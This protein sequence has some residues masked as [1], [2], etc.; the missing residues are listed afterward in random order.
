MKKKKISIRIKFSVL[1]FLLICVI[2]GLSIWIVSIRIKEV[3]FKEINLRGALI[4]KNLSSENVAELLMLEEMNAYKYDIE[5]A[6]LIKEAMNNE[7][8]VYAL[9]VDRHG[10]IR[11]HNDITQ[12]EKPYILPKRLQKIK[13]EKVLI[14][15]YTQKKKLI[16]NISCP[17]LLGETK[18]IGTVHIGISHKSI[19]KAI[20]TTCKGIVLISLTTLSVGLLGTLIL[21]NFMIKP[22]HKLVKGVSAIAK[23]DLNQYIEV[24]SKDEIGELTHAFN[25]MTKSLREKELIKNAFARYVTKQVLEVILKEPEKIILGGEKKEVTILFA[26]IRGFTSIAE[27][28]PPEEVVNLL[29]EYLSLMTEII[30]KYEGTLDKFIGD[31]IMAVFGTPIAHSDDCQRAVKSAIDIQKTLRNSYKFKQNLYIGIGINNGEVISGNIGSKERT[32]YTVIGDPVNI[33]A[34]LEEEAKS[35]QILISEALYEKVK[36]IVIAEKLPLMHLKGKKTPLQIYNVKEL[37]N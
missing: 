3:L 24:Q 21:V 16:Y 33:A 5:F 11:A 7:S 14:Q 19:D 18:R 35:E 17:I 25:Q 12:W 9:I 20:F 26:D 4:A 13:N 32:D 31:C 8:I 30:F 10:K 29:N 34:R 28:L 6:N 23:G 2:M 37:R 27:N 15:L 1:I 22:I 36:D